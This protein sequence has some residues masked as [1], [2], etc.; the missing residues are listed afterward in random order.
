M[1]HIL[2]VVE[3]ILLTSVER[4]ERAN[5]GNVLAVAK[6]LM[7]CLYSGFSEGWK[8]AI[9]LFTITINRELLFKTNT[10]LTDVNRL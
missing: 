9:D 2:E 5:L 7:K 8:T 6:Q 4:E 10:M 3:T 1:V